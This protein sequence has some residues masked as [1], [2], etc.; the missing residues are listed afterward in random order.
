MKNKLIK[1]QIQ[2]FLQFDINDNG[3]TIHEIFN[4]IAKSNFENIIFKY[5][6]I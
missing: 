4:L 1:K 5:I 2:A 6:Y 3:W